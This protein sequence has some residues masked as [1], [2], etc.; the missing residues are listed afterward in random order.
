MAHIVQ[1]P[2]AASVCGSVRSTQEYVNCVAWMPEFHTTTS[3]CKVETGALWLLQTKCG[4][5]GSV[6]SL[7]SS[8][9]RLG[10][11]ARLSPADATYLV[12]LSCFCSSLRARCLCFG[13]MKEA[14]LQEETCSLPYPCFHL[15]LNSWRHGHGHECRIR[16]SQAMVVA[17]C[18]VVVDSLWRGACAFF[19]RAPATRC[20]CML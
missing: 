18:V 8:Q 20:F 15:F 10:W 4:Y 9:S 19:S 17:S 6:L 3:G 2:R 12:S 16:F 7:F 14:V 11:V 1:L 13:H 5:V